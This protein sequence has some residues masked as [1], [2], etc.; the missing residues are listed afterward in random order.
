MEYRLSALL[1]V[2]DAA[3]AKG[4]DVATIRRACQHGLLKCTKINDR[5]WVIRWRDLA[6]WEPQRQRRTRTELEAARQ[7]NAD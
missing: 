7:S 3:V 5:A 6:R 1:S 2:K 4:V